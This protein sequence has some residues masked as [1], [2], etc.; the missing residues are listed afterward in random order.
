MFNRLQNLYK[1]WLLLWIKPMPLKT[2]PNDVRSVWL[3]RTGALG[4]LFIISMFPRLIKK[5]WPNCRL[6][7]IVGKPFIEVWQHNPYIDRIIAVDSIRKNYIK[8]FQFAKTIR[9]DS[10]DIFLSLEP[11]ISCSLLGVLAKPRWGCSVGVLRL[12]HYWSEMFFDLKKNRV[13]FFKDLAQVVGLD[14]SDWR[15]EIFYPK[16]EFEEK[17][18]QLIGPKSKVRI[19]LSPW[20]GSW[21]AK[22]W[23][24]NLAA[25]FCDLLFERG[26]EVILLGIAADQENAKKL[27]EMSLYKPLNLVGKT[28]ITE[29][30]AV[31]KNI[32]A[33]ISCDCGAAHL[34]ATVN[35]PQVVLFGPTNAFEWTPNNEMLSTLQGENCPECKPRYLKEKGCQYDYNCMKHDPSVVLNQLLKVLDYDNT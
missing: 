21:Y 16:Q 30:T 25:T 9:E 1:H 33:V 26:F 28:T 11:D 6:N 5:K 19:G 29:L 31:I 24:I 23:P 4:D 20:A 8:L 12:K 34:A 13:A 35:K 22:N 17:A 14:T 15:Q 10:V 2:P 27:I 3:V 32:D 18:Q 7:V